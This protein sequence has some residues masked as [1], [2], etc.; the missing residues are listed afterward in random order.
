MVPLPDFLQPFRSEAEKYLAKGLVHDIEFSGPTYQ[1]QVVDAASK[2]EVWSFL[3]LDNRGSIKDSFCSCEKGEELSY[4]VHVAAAFLRIYNGELIPLHQRFQNSLW[5]KLCEL[6]AER[7]GDDPDLL[8]KKGRAH[9]ARTSP[10][11]KPLFFIKGKTAE[12]KSKLIDI[13]EHRRK[14]TEETSLKF[15]NLTEE[16]IN[17]WREGKPS[18]QL[19]YELSY[20]NDLAHWLMRLQEDGVKY[21][22]Q[23]G[24]SEKG[25]PNQITILFPDF[26]VGFYISE[27]NL[28]SIIPTLATVRSPLKVYGASHENISRITYDKESGALLIET[29]KSKGKKTEKTT[30]PAVGRPI[31]GW[32]FV[33]KDGFYA[34]DQNKLLAQ[35]QLTGDQVNQALTEHTM[36]IQRLLEGAVLHIES[37]VLSYFVRFDT[38]WN[39]HIIAYAFNPGDLSTGFSRIFGKW[40]YVDN[41]GFYPIHEAPFVEADTMIPNKD[42]SDFVTQERSWLNTQEGFATHLSHIESQLTYSLGTDNRLRFARLSAVLEEGESKDFDAWVYIKGQG[43]YAKRS[44]VT[45]LPLQA[46]IAISPEQIPLFIRNNRNEVALVP[47]FFSDKCPVVGGELHVTLTDDDHINITPVYN[48]LPE[49]VNRDVRFFD[50]FVYVP[51]EGFSELPV[52]C[53]LPDKY[54]HSV[55]IESADI[56]AFLSDELKSLKHYIK[57]LDP[58]L[59]K[60]EKVQLTASSIAKVDEE[61]FGGYAL[62]L[63]YE[64]EFGLIPIDEV[65]EAIKKKHRFLFSEGG[66]LDLEEKRFDWI[67]AVPRSH[68]DKRS[69]TVKLTTLELIRLHALDPI[70]VRKDVK[71]AEQSLALLKEL[72]EFHVPEEPDLSGLR[73]DLRP[74]QHLGVHWL[75][76]LYRHGLSGLL[77]DDM[78]LGKTHQAMALFCAA[79]NYAKKNQKPDAKPLHFLVVCPTSVIYH[80]QEKLQQFLPEMRICVFHGGS[81]SLEEFHQQYDILLTSYG[82]WRL[83]HALLSTI[84]FEVA[85]L[86]E[87]Q[88]AKNHRSRLHNSLRHINAKMR[89]GLTGTPIENRLREM[90]SLFDLVLPT[91]MPGEMEFRELFVKP[92]E[93]DND[94]ERRALLTRFIKPFILRRKKNEVLLDL[95]DKTEEISHCDLS[96]EQQGLY[97]QVLQKSRERILE[98]LQDETTTVPYM[99]IFAL[100]SSLKQICN[101]PA[102]YYKSAEDYKKHASG[103]WDLFVEL[104]NEARDSEQK[105]VIFSQYLTM[106]DILEEYLNENEIGFATIRGA[107]VNRGEEVYRF[108]HD[109]KCEVFLGSLQAAGLGV[110]LTAGSVVIHYDRWWNAAREDQATDRVH[111]IGQTRGV[112]VFK[113]VTKGTFEERIDAMI[114]RKGKLMEEVVRTDD[115]R[116]IKAFDRKELLELLEDVEESKD[117]VEGKEAE[118]GSEDEEPNA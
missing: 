26:E 44:A 52:E 17:L 23:F 84:P 15:S 76:F 90:K 98:Q 32:I 49:Y 61:G 73:S 33:P 99:H 27:A 101:H 77:C 11:G 88:I 72:T 16:E 93:R 14:E 85:I 8:E 65:W 53:R 47:H 89:L 63:S 29:K 25:L 108:N 64:T 95:P 82:I 43:F 107:T 86:D 34:R 36:L 9:Y 39:L 87:I 112:Q 12:A 20:W 66:R 38:E 57:D 81:R 67:K 31:N 30:T 51:G 97:N 59:R 114:A 55:V 40:I 58:R 69:N 104:L 22:I 118:G 7:I 18:A 28:P 74:Y 92:I 79:I 56:A 37:I 106:L 35:P 13:I 100:L 109:P 111:R 54:H 116:F 71:G 115:H 96:S 62:K 78:G 48:L 46:D 4:C 60:P 41:D 102:V 68:I 91:Y 117:E 103:K 1:V 2:Q 70:E 105:V 21:E 45:S 75:W 19:R 113:L 3:Q 50:D 110:D 6:F 24:Y 80:W 83:E 5:N 42:V 10:G 94:P